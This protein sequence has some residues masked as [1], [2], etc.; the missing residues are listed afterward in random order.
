VSHEGTKD[1]KRT[2]RRTAKLA[3]N[4]KMRSGKWKWRRMKADR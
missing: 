1:T 4:A 3:K 2:G